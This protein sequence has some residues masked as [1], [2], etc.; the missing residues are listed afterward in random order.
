MRLL[1]VSFA[2]FVVG[3]LSLP[4]RYRPFTNGFDIL[5]G[6]FRL[7]MQQGRGRK[8]HFP[9]GRHFAD[10]LQPLVRAFA[11]AMRTG[12]RPGGEIQMLASVI[13]MVDDQPGNGRDVAVPR[14]S[15]I[16]G[17]TVPARALKHGG[18]RRGDLRIRPQRQPCLDRRICFGRSNELSRRQHSR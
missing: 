13:H 18:H 16:V 6:K 15:R 1:F 3:C 5:R 11:E 14:P 8:R 9:A 12:V 2:N 4:L 10:A 17:V 7:V